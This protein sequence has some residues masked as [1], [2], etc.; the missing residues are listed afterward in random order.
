M[1]DKHFYSLKGERIMPRKEGAYFIVFEGP[2]GAGKTTQAGLLKAHLEG[3]GLKV[4]L[5][6]EPTA[7]TD[8]GRRVREILN[9]HTKIDP[10]ELQ[11]LFV[12]DRREH[13][14]KDI[15]PSLNEGNIVICD[16]YFFSTFAYGYIDNPNIYR[17]V[18]LNKDFLQPDIT[19]LLLVDPEKCIA[20]LKGRASSVDAFEK[21]EKLKKVNEGYRMIAERFKNIQIIDGEKTIEEV[22]QEITNLLKDAIE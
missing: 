10:E 22:N 7:E 9:S 3:F 4:L 20:R 17:L 18:D 12:E 1:L 8:A 5:T 2:D 21:I 11:R 16:R 13:L 6:K 14:I 19:F 15:V